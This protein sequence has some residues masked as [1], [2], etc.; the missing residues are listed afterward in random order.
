[1]STTITTIT[2][3]QSSP[4]CHLSPSSR[5][6]QSS[7][8]ADVHKNA[9]RSVVAGKTSHHRKS[10]G[11]TGYPSNRK[12]GFLYTAAVEKK[13]KTS[14]L[15]PRQFR[16]SMNTLVTSSPVA[17]ATRLFQ[18]SFNVASRLFQ[19]CFKG[20]S[21]MFQGYFK[22]VTRVILGYFKGV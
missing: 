4:C 19:G 1:M 16:N 7:R 22:G 2:P 10:T 21:R 14:I 5:A 3:S 13:C 12:Q 8:K 17:I 20:V 11:A 9:V 15:R 6:R 18:G